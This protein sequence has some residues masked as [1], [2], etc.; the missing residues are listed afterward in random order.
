MVKT[1]GFLAR[2]KGL[3]PGWGTMISHAA[4]CGKNKKYQYM[5]FRV[6]G[7]HTG[8]AESLSGRWKLALLTALS[9]P[10]E[11]INTRLLQSGP[12]SLGSCRG[13]QEAF[14]CVHYGVTA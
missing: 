13:S 3:I 7:T 12:E 2:G 14:Q 10:T 1:A 6:S 4:L 11:N 5:S 9:L 8:V